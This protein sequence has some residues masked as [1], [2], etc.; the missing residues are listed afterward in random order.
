MSNGD[1]YLSFI[2]A[3]YQHKLSDAAK[4]LNWRKSPKLYNAK[5]CFSPGPKDS[6]KIFMNF[7]SAVK[8][9]EQWLTSHHFQ[10]PLLVKGKLRQIP[11]SVFFDCLFIV[12]INNPNTWREFNHGHWLRH[13]FLWTSPQSQFIHEHICFSQFLATSLL[14]A[15]H[16]NYICMAKAWKF[17]SLVIKGYKHSEITRSILFSL[18]QIF[19]NWVR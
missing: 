14:S 18:A 6:K 17:V 1:F 11:R 8:Y 3:N 10:G 16:L 9:T 19:F 12:I 13:N 2:S 15:F 7:L 4:K 5:T